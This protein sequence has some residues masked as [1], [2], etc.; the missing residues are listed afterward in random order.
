MAQGGSVVTQPVAY[1]TLPGPCGVF[2]WFCFIYLFVYLFLFTFWLH[3][4]FV[5]AHGLSLVAVSGGCSSLRC[6]GFSL[7]CLL[8]LQSTG[9]RRAGFSSCG[10]WAQ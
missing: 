9:S 5:A 8:L 10:L 3:W 2:F 4:V 6:A 7:W 1:W